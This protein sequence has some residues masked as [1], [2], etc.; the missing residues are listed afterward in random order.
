MDSSLL[1]ALI[2]GSSLALVSSAHCVVMC[3]PLAL[4]SRV[5][6]GAGATISY[7]GGRIV[8]YTVAGAIAGSVGHALLLSPWA[9]WAEAVLSW[10][11]AATLLFAGLSALRTGRAPRLVALGKGPRVSLLGRVLARLADDP[12][13]LG[14][15]TAL[16]PCSALF[17]ALAA[18]AALG[19]ARDGALAMLAFSALTGAA[20]VGVAQLGGLRTRGPVFQRALGA[21]LLV[22]AV[23]MGMRPIPMLRAGEGVPACHGGPSAPTHLPETL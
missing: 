19:S 16:L 2:S 8:S 1:I 21:A 22:G 11:L 23:V 18:A 13:L 17:S 20:I 5:R 3:G 9:R 10:L 15:A 14:A 7:F 12:L 6:G 4:S